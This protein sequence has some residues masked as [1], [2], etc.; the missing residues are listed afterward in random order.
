MPSGTLALSRAREC[1][2]RARKTC[3][4]MVVDEWPDRSGE[5][6]GFLGIKSSDERELKRRVERLILT[7]DDGDGARA[8]ACV[9]VRDSC[10]IRDVSDAR[11]VILHSLVVAP[12][13]RRNGFGEVTA[14]RAT[15]FA[16][17]EMGADVATVWCE[18]GLVDWYVERCGFTREPPMGR[19]LDDDGGDVCCRAFANEEVRRRYQAT[20]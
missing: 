20:F 14:R 5:S 6:A 4:L 16:F 15:E 10:A 19:T 17:K 9:C 11:N 13:S 3:A 12:T 1:D 8:V 2:A 18:P 7:V